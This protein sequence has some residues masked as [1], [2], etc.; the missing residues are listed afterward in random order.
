MMWTRPWSAIVLGEDRK[1]K[2]RVKW[3]RARE[4]IMTEAV[5]KAILGIGWWFGRDATPFG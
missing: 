3:K 4:R 5:I 2:A 1:K